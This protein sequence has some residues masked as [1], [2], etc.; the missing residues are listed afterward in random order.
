MTQNFL[1]NFS[2]LQNKIFEEFD[3]DGFIKNIIDIG[4]NL[5]TLLKYT[6]NQVN[7]EVSF[8]FLLLKKDTPD[9]FNYA[10]EKFKKEESPEVLK[11]FYNNLWKGQEQLSIV[12]KKIVSIDNI[13]QITLQPWNVEAYFKLQQDAIALFKEKNEIF[14]FKD[15]TL[16]KIDTL[17]KFPFNS[18]LFKDFFSTKNNESNILL[19]LE[20]IK[21]F[22]NHSFDY[23]LKINE[24]PELTF[25][26][27]KKS[28]NKEK[29]ISWIFN[30]TSI[31]YS[32]FFWHDS[33]FSIDNESQKEIL[34]YLILNKKNENKQIFVLNYYYSNFILCSG[35]SFL[36]IMKNYI[37]MIEN[38]S[39]QNEEG[40]L[41]IKNLVET[42]HEEELKEQD[43]INFILADKQIQLKEIYQKE[44]IKHEIL[45]EKQN[46]LKNIEYPE[47]KNN[48][49]RI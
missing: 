14:N 26:F 42:H 35:D 24:T 25:N 1:T 38:I 22:Y 4:I 37:S 16:N 18:K 44:I 21:H 46:I 23:L 29:I 36:Q 43:I 48:K 28:Q 11:N 30:N 41:F 12:N 2:S 49:K 7:F 17:F 31:D 13:I 39:N 19:F 34:P 40:K 27:L 9:S 5:P 47:I 6:N 33:F 10:Y 15:K 32:T 8:I 45:I 20:N 3:N